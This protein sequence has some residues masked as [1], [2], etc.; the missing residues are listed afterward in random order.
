MRIFCVL[1]ECACLRVRVIVC[2]CVI[3]LVVQQ[4]DYCL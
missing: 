4:C 3:R 1:S 2:M